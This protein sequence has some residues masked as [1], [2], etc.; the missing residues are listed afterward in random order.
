MPMV[1]I[2]DE[3]KSLMDHNRNLIKGEYITYK[4]FLDSAV[5]DKLRKMK[6]PA[7]E[8][9]IIS[10]LR[11]LRES[12]SRHLAKRSIDMAIQSHNLRIAR[13]RRNLDSM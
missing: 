11:Q 7:G 10:H 6:I 8:D 5:R 1:T 3:L 4:L 12:K 9:E 2:S 13:A